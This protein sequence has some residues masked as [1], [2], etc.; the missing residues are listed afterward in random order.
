MY[1]PNLGDIKD[2]T[3][4]AYRDAGFR[5]LPD[6]VSSVRG[7]VMVETNRK[8]KTLCLVGWRSKKLKRI[9][10]SPTG[11]EIV[12]MNKAIGEVVC[13]K[14]I[15]KEM[16]GRGVAREILVIVYMDS[17]RAAPVQQKE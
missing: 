4:E 8:K 16:Q 3:V 7:W 14:A 12:V 13:I 2:W 9:V 17:K 1:F 11:A 6:G 10:K 5:C 15:L